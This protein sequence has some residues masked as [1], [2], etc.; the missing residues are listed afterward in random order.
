M[1]VNGKQYITYDELLAELRNPQRPDEDTLSMLR[2]LSCAN[3]HTPEIQD[4]ID[5]A[6][7]EIEGYQDRQANEARERAEYE[8]TQHAIRC[9]PDVT[10]T[11]RM[12]LNRAIGELVSG[13]GELDA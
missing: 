4:A 10:W 6:I 9:L 1:I 7:G 3:A 13:F 12:A 2:A 8:Q 11:E 5:G